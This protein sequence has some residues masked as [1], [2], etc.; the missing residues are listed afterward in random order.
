MSKQPPSESYSSFLLK[1]QRGKMK[2]CISI[3]LCT[4]M[5]TQMAKIKELM[6]CGFFRQIAVVFQKIK[7]LM[8]MCCG[9]SR[10]IAVVF[11]KIKELMCRGKKLRN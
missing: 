10:Q 8:L 9:F 7:E 11:Q 6:C 2:I 1:K 3:T 4:S 5:N